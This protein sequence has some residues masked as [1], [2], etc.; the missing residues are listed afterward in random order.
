[1]LFIFATVDIWHNKGGVRG[2]CKN[3]LN[4]QGLF[5]LKG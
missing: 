2:E 1:M 4:T 3:D 5:A